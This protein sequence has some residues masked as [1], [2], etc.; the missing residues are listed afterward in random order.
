MNFEHLTLKESLP[1][2]IKGVW[3]IEVLRNVGTRKVKETYRS[4]FKRTI[5]I[6][7]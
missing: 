2:E 4:K 5:T 1:S 3:G 6:E 7:N